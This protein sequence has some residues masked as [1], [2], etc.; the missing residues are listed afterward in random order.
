MVK[1]PPG[2]SSSCSFG[3]P[4]S[5]AHRSLL[6][7]LHEKDN[8]RVAFRWALEI[9]GALIARLHILQV[10]PSGSYQVARRSTRLFANV[11]RSAG[12]V[13][14][15]ARQTG[16]PS[17]PERARKGGIES[18]AVLQGDFVE[19]TVRYA[20]A[21]NPGLILLANDGEGSGELAKLLAGTVRRPV[22][23]AGCSVG[24]PIPVT[25]STIL[26]SEAS[27]LLATF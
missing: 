6:V 2:D 17:D 19:Q 11:L 13:G 23:V 20:A 22:L 26:A 14:P 4:S 15:S 27:E 25:A 12:V 21:T 9:A 18:A 24:V 8:P 5:S 16:A 3:S 7:A 1:L 10:V